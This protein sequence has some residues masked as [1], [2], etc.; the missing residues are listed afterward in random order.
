MKS[1]K[2]VLFISLVMGV[3]STTSLGYYFGINREQQSHWPP[4]TDTYDEEPNSDTSG[5]NGARKNL[6]STSKA[7]T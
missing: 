2:I 7:D 3:V 6:Y 4:V 1:S 5:T